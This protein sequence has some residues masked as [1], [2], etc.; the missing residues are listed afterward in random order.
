MALPIESPNRYKAMKP[1]SVAVV[2]IVVGCSAVRPKSTPKEVRSFLFCLRFQSAGA[3][4]SL[5]SS[6][7]FFYKSVG[8]GVC[9][10]FWANLS[11]YFCCCRRLL[12][13][14]SSFG[15]GKVYK[16]YKL[17]TFAPA[18]QYI[19]HLSISTYR[20]DISCSKF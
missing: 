14:Q 4:S 8:V 12:G 10:G 2:G 20:F 15:Y 7:F 18:I 3:F 11:E 13:K 16:P 6:P 1:F 5:T 19:I 17:S 9:S